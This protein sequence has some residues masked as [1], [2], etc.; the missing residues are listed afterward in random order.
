[1]IALEKETNFAS[2]QTWA[3]SL[4]WSGDSQY[5]IEKNYEGSSSIAA[6]EVLRPGEVI[7]ERGQSYRL[8]IF[9]LSIQALA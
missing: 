4:A 2:G 6:G 3:L 8:L 9:L 1:M 7:L 5:C